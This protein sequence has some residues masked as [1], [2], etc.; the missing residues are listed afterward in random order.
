MSKSDKLRIKDY[1][2]HIVEAIE[3]INRYVEHMSEDEFYR[4]EKNRMP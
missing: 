4:D 3:R 1:L 2:T